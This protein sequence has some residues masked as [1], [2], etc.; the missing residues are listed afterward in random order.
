MSITT[1]FDV[2]SIGL[3]AVE[4]FT[5]RSVSEHYGADR[6]AA[7]YCGIR[8]PY[9]VPH[10]LWAH[11]WTQH[12]C[13]ADPILSREY[14]KLHD[15]RRGRD[16][17]WTSLA[18][19]VDFIREYGWTSKAIGLP[20]VYLPDRPAT[21]RPGSLLVMPV[22]SGE[23]TTFNWQGQEYA[24]TIRSMWS[25]FSDV[26]ICVH[27]SCLVNGHWVNEFR[28]QGF[29]IV[30]GCHWADANG[31]RRLQTLLGSFEYVTTNGFGSHIAYG[32]FF[33]A[34]VS[35]YGRFIEPDFE[36]CKNDFC[37][38]EGNRFYELFL[39][40]HTEPVLRHHYPFLFCHPAEATERVAWGRSEV[41]YQ[42]KISPQEMRDLFRWRDADLLRW[43]L[44]GRQVAWCG[45]TARRLVPAPAKRCIKRVLGLVQAGRRRA[46][47][48][49]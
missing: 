12:Y 25:S 24:K 15:A 36:A 45:A 13:A 3:P 37:Y 29:P 28:A 18:E 2:R 10:G 22:H 44:G 27:P 8:P 40:S 30:E 39:D 42:H 31:L 49:C 23:R 46:S 32:A 35:I 4:R 21:R 1:E 47:Q 48:L 5:P 6:V 41:G 38:L 33:G 20:V 26:V 14:L 9:P 17:L 34:K 16:D 11:A 19:A 43:R 7:E